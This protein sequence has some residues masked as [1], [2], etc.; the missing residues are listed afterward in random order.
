MDSNDLNKLCAHQLRT[1]NKAG[2]LDRSHLLAMAV[3][4]AVQAAGQQERELD[5]MGR[6]VYDSMYRDRSAHLTDWVH[7]C[8]EAVDR[9]SAYTEREQLLQLM[10]VY[11]V[12]WLVART[13]SNIA[14]L[15]RPCVRQVAEYIIKEHS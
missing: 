1:Y 13:G 8:R 15:Y 6:A 9:H 7:E 12:N 14:E 11:V 4:T 2:P 3:E 5:A 10:D